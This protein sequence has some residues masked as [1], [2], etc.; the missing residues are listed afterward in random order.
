MSLKLPK[1]AHRSYRKKANKRHHTKPVA[2]K[3]TTRKRVDN[4]IST[5]R[6]NYLRKKNPSSTSVDPI[7]NMDCIVEENDME[8]KSYSYQEGYN[9]GYY[10]GGEA[11][12]LAHIPPYN[13]LPELNCD[14]VIAA[15]VRSLSASLISL[16]APYSVYEE[17]H[18]SM[19]LR[20]PLSVIR[21][22]DGELLALAAGTV[23][24]IEEAIRQ[25][26]FLP[27]SGFNVDDDT[28][29]EQLVMSIKRANIVGVPISRF[30]TFQGLLF[31]VL[32]YFGISYQGLRMTSSTLNYALQEQ[33]LLA[34]LLHGR[35]V[36]IVGN[37]AHNL[38]ERLAREG[39]HIVGTVAPV[40]GMSNIPEVMSAIS[41]YDFDLALV[42]AGIPAVIIC[43]R[44]ATDLGK[45]ALDFGH[46]AHKLISEEV[47]FR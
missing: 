17:M 33:G 12:V 16:L 35:K 8:L 18:N 26:M 5:K 42:S 15:G 46:L 40:N 27:Q 20:K 14:D 41:A 11:R 22:G 25:G 3:F 38:N 4:H 29:R 37:T 6:F 32:Q 34:P 1:L 43:E 45:V 23:L 2:K 39:I 44:I 10:E 30:P 28:G 21:L 31:P 13:I 24:P 47:S 9:A 19:D 7:I 36:L